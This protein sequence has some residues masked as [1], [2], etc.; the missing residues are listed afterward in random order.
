MVRFCCACGERK[1]RKITFTKQIGFHGEESGNRVIIPDCRVLR[2]D[3]SIRDNSGLPQKM[4]DG[5]PIGVRERMADHMS[6]C[7]ISSNCYIT[8]LHPHSSALIYI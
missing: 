5:L 3:L 8:I 2:Y 7:R 6:A 1:E 4:C